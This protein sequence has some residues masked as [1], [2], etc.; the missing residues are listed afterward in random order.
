[1]F[2]SLIREPLLNKYVVNPLDLQYRAVGIVKDDNKG[3]PPVNLQQ[4]YF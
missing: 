1:M 2:F 4:Y 3:S